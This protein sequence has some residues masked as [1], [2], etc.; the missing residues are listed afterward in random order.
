MGGS[1][2]LSSNAFLFCNYPYK[3]FKVQPFRNSIIKKAIPINK[4]ISDK[5]QFYTDKKNKK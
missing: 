3:A 1:L 5:K 2:N 4:N